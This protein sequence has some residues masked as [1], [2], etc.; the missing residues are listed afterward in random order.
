MSLQ[1]DVP[2]YYG[3]NVANFFIRSWFLSFLCVDI[4]VINSHTKVLTSYKRNGYA[5]SE[6]VQGRSCVSIIVKYRNARKE[7]RICFQKDPC[8]IDMDCNSCP[9]IARYVTDLESQNYFYT[10]AWFTKLI[11]IH[12]YR[13]YGSC[14]IHD[15]RPVVDFLIRLHYIEFR[16]SY[17]EKMCIELH[18]TVHDSTGLRSC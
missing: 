3:T 8:K 12:R 16:A 13:G 4:P 6:L 5:S 11:G 17:N 7:K 2:V 10:Q 14:Y 9:P 18:V 15:T 1:I